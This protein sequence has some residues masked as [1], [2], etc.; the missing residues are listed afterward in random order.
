MYLWIVTLLK[1][2]KCERD[3]EHGVFKV[4]IFW[5]GQFCEIFTLLL[6]TVCTVVK[7]KVKVSQILW[8][9]QNIWTLIYGWSL[10][11]LQQ[12]FFLGT[13]LRKNNLIIVYSDTKLVWI[14]SL[15][16]ALD[17]EKYFSILLQNFKFS[18]HLSATFSTSIFNRKKSSW[19]VKCTVRLIES[20]E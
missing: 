11:Y 10:R 15:I 3:P 6:L 13:K 2:Q 18:H 9:F 14:K 17:I 8:P 7:S 16:C 20:T 12:L 5:V 19:K 4:H 1:M